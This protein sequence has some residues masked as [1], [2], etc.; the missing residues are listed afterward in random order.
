MVKTEDVRA[1]YRLI[2]GREPE[3]EETVER[4][5]MGFDSL[6][7]LRTAFLK[8]PEFHSN[9]STPSPSRP[10]EWPSVEVEVD[11]SPSQ[12]SSMMRHIEAN[13]RQLGLSDPHWSV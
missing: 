5:A 1:A 11:A 7:D 8:S 9:G 13:W 3:S 10:L 2:L 12:L 6:A 4:H